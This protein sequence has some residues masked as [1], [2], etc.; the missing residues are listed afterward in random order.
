[1][2]HI[3]HIGRKPEM[4]DYRVS[5]NEIDSYVQVKKKFEN[6]KRLRAEKN[7]NKSCFLSLVIIVVI[8]ILIFNLITN[9]NNS[10]PSDG[11]AAVF[12]I[13]IAICLCPFLLGKVSNISEKAVDIATDSPYINYSPNQAATKR[14]QEALEKYEKIASDLRSRYPNI[15]KFDYDE[16]RYTK[17]VINEL[18]GFIEDKFRLRNI[19]WWKNQ[20]LN[21]KIAIRKLLIADGFQRV[22]YKTNLGDPVQAAF[23]YQVDITAEKNGVK[24]YFRCFGKINGELEVKHL[25]ALQLVKHD[26][27]NSKF[28]IV[29]NYS[30]KQISIDVKNYIE[31]NNIEF[32]DVIKLVELTKQHFVDTDNDEYPLDLHYGFKKCMGFKLSNNLND[33]MLS[34]QTYFYYIYTLELFNSAKEALEAMSKF[35]K[36]HVYYGVCEYPKVKNYLYDDIDAEKPQ[37]INFR[38]EIT[39]K[40]VFAIIASASENRHNWRIRVESEYLF[41]AFTREYIHNKHTL[42]VWNKY[43]YIP[44][45]LND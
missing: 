22:K 34:T 14:F 35:P 7:N 32:W 45:I 28:V 33:D 15:E 39:H 43:T 29:T 9:S 31:D 42:Y 44:S 40:A 3:P 36:E 1:M 11:Q 17:F 27:E 4:S 20:T 25:E 23:S 21:F 38:D 2:L 30:S 6:E 5:Q 8:A 16:G 19:T 12:V 41:D 37:M 18:I 26:L 24:Y 10:N 13:I